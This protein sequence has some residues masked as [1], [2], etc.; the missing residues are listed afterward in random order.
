MSILLACSSTTRDWHRLIKP[1]EYLSAGADPT[2]RLEQRRKVV[3]V[4]RASPTI[5]DPF[6]RT[7]CALPDFDVVLSSDPSET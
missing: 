4:C 1:N 3:R 5:N 6:P 2:F 7:A